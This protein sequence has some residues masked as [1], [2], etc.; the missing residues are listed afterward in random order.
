MNLNMITRFQESI[1]Y[2]TMTGDASAARPA[3]SPLLPN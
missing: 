3:L 1:W 2:Q